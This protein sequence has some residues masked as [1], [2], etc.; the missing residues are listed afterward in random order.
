MCVSCDRE[1]DT[2][3]D[4]TLKDMVMSFIFILAVVASV[5]AKSQPSKTIQDSGNLSP[6]AAFSSILY[7]M[8]ILCEREG[9]W[10]GGVYLHSLHILDEYCDAVEDEECNNSEDVGQR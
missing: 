2:W 6:T 7:L 8:A 9:D 3:L 4:L 5:M 10:M 1:H